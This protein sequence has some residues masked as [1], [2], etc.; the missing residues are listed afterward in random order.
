MCPHQV[1]M[2]HLDFDKSGTINLY[3]L[4]SNGEKSKSTNNLGCDDGGPRN[5]DETPGARNK[6]AYGKI[7]IKF[8]LSQ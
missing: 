4:D 3:E 8:V 2:E 6:E 5:G 1:F 7:S